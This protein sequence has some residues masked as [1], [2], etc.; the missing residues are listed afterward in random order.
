MA[1]Y[2]CSSSIVIVLFA[3]V[4]NLSALPSGPGPDDG[5]LIGLIASERRTETAKPTV[6]KQEREQ[7]DAVDV[8]GCLPAWRASRIDPAAVLRER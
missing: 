7:R 3:R 2:G 8:S 6:V 1:S 5:V 4:C